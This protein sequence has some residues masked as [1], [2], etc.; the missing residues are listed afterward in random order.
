[1]ILIWKGRPVEM[2]G[3]VSIIEEYREYLR[4]QT[5][6]EKRVQIQMLALS[7]RICWML[8]CSILYTN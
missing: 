2:Y 8:Q 5:R 6:C 3:E 4:T 7:M 1:M